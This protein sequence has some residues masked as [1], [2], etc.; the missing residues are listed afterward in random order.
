[1]L[2]VFIDGK[3]GRLG[4]ERVENGFDQQH[5]TAAF[6][7][8][9]HL[10]KIRAAQ[11]FKGDIA[12]PGVIHIRADAGGFGCWPQG[13]HHKPGVLWRRIFVAGG[14]GQPRRGQ[15]HLARQVAQV[16]V[17]LGDGGCAKGIG[18]NQVS[19]GSQIG[20]VDVPDHIGPGDAEQVA[21]VFDVFRV[22]RKALTAVIGFGQLEALDHGAHGP[23]QNGDAP[24]QQGRQG[25]ASCV[26]G[27]FVCGDGG[28]VH[29]SAAAGRFRRCQV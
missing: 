23:I 1:M 9:L 17:S 26:G 13:A 14:T 10:F 16:I 24:G 18:F 11:F 7:Q 6:H 22:G 27:K 20:F 28:Q 25:L 4:V 29:C 3:Q 8:C 5:I 21:I 2:K 19:P 12:G 15:V